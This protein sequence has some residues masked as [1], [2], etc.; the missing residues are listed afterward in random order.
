M[1]IIADLEKRYTQLMSIFLQIRVCSFHIFLYMY[2]NTYSTF[3]NKSPHIVG[4]LN[5]SHA[6]FLPLY[7]YDTTCSIDREVRYSP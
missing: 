3:T 5:L 2:Y 7:E 4:P 1:V 6:I